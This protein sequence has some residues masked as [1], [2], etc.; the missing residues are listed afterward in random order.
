MDDYDNQELTALRDFAFSYRWNGDFGCNRSGSLS[1][2]Q[3]LWQVRHGKYLSREDAV[4]IC[5]QLWA[6]GKLAFEC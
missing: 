3:A 5:R 6:S 4:A 2:L 1:R